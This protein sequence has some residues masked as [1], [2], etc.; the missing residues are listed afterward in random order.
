[1]GPLRTFSEG[2]AGGAWRFISGG[3]SGGPAGG[4]GTSSGSPESINVVRSQIF[5]SFFEKQSIPKITPK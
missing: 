1:M 3:V 2:V 5:V 4:L